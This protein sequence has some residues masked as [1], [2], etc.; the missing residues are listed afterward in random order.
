M[1]TKILAVM[2][3]LVALF[4]FFIA[5]C[6]DNGKITANESQSQEEKLECPRGLEHEPAPGSCPLYRDENNDGY[7]DYE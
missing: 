5:G 3:V 4:S 2:F 6:S 7:C 1:K